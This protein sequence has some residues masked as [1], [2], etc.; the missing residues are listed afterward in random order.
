MSGWMQM[1]GMLCVS[2]RV[3]VCLGVEWVG[4]GM[5]LCVSVRVW[6]WEGC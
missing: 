6:L 1:R 5:G 3:R 4:V 2:V